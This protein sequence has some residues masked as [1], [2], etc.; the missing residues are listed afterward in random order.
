MCPQ[1]A[2]SSCRASAPRPVELTPH[3]QTLRVVPVSG[4]AALD[5]SE[6]T[7]QHEPWGQHPG[8]LVSREKLAVL[9]I[10]RISNP[11]LS[12]ANVLLNMYASV[13]S[14]T[15]V[16]FCGKEIKCFQILHPLL[17]K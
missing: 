2:V 6:V 12:P 17:W 16:I 3:A 4:A 11:L 10:T 5:V 14:H 7:A 15:H 9:K 13:M 8:S 1:A